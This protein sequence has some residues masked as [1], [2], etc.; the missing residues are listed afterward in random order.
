MQVLKDEVRNN[1]IEAATEE[2][3][4][5]GY[6][7]SSLRIIASKAGMTIGNIYSYFSSKDNLFETVIDPALKGLKSLISLDVTGYESK[8]QPSLI[9][10]TEEICQVFM[11]NKR[12]FLILMNGSKGSQFKD[13]RQD[14]IDFISDRIEKEIYPRASSAQ[15]DPLFAKALASGIVSS[16]ITVFNN[17]GGDEGR[18]FYLVNELIYVVLGN[19]ESRL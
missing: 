5:E 11:A 1:L 14:I 6:N 12:G 2:F 10:I 13:I 17:Y 18:L 4:A 9:E 16:F 3:L 8:D 15:M 7:N 19:I